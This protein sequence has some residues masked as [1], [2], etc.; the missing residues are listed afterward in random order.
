MSKE[1]VQA[2][3]FIDVSRGQLGILKIFFK[4]QFLD[5]QTDNFVSD[6]N[7]NRSYM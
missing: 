5:F 7:V 3:R 2:V 1:I 6:Y 4:A